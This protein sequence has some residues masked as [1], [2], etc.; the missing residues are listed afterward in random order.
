MTKNHHIVVP[1]ACT[2]FIVIRMRA[3]G[4]YVRCFGAHNKQM[5]IFSDTFVATTQN[6]REA[7]S[8]RTRTL[9]SI[10]IV[11]DKMVFTQIRPPNM[12]LHRGSDNALTHIFAALKTIVFY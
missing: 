2:T 6:I 8:P 11:T 4:R 5:T 10:E 9:A 7:Q 12:W 1:C 3:A